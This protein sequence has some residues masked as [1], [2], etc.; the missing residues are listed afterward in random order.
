[1]LTD[2]ITPQA[3]Y[4]ADGFQSVL[5][6]HENRMR[7][8]VLLNG[9]LVQNDRTVPESPRMVIMGLHRL[10]PIARKTQRRC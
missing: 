4:F 8:I 5:R 10:P 1:M 3:A 6:G 9:N 7:R 2:I